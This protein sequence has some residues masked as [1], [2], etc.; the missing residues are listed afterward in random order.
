MKHL[1]ITRT[2][3]EKSENTQPEMGNPE[4]TRSGEGLSIVAVMLGIYFMMMP[5]D[6]FP[7]FGMGSLLRIIALFPVGAIIVFKLRH[8]IGINQLTVSFFVYCLSITASVFY[9]INRSASFTSLSRV[10]LNMV[11]VLCVGGMYEYNKKEIEFLKRSLV[12]GGLGTL[13]LTLIFSDTS[14]DGRLTLSING[15][16]QDQNYLNGYLFFAY[17]YFL[18]R[19]IRKRRVLSAIPVGGII[20]FTLLTGSRGALVS[21][22]GITL[23]VL[24]YI[25]HQE[26]R[27]TLRVILILAAIALLLAVLY[28]PILSILP[29]AVSKRFSVEYVMENGST[30]RSDIW[31]YLIGRFL[32]ADLFRTLF[33]FGYATVVLVNEYNRLVAHNLWLDHLIMGGLIGEA[34]FIYMQYT[35]IKAAWRSKDPFLVGSYIGFLIMMLTLS[36]L[37]YKPIW[38]CMM[39]IMIVTNYQS[40]HPGT[41]GADAQAAASPE[42]RIHE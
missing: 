9:S 8:T 39:M 42:G 12:A 1:E 23:A 32:E 36:L 27:L 6:S 38:N 20:Y 29:E 24:L 4:I 34:V 22:A 13:A 35:Y 25:L 3:M 2:T 10:L 30:G 18:T 21:L 26:H 40:R 41:Y 31:K 14:T 28:Q 37:S 17:V 11:I 19:L 16:V 7:M 5:F 33:G 15:T